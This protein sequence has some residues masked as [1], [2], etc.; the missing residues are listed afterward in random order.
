MRSSAARILDTGTG[1]AEERFEELKAEL[2]RLVSNDPRLMICPADPLRDGSEF[3]GGVVIRPRE[4]TLDRYVEMRVAPCVAE[5]F[6]QPER[7][8]TRRVL[9]L[10]EGYCVDTCE[11]GSAQE[12]GRV[13]VGTL[14]THLEWLEHAVDPQ[15]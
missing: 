6:L 3:N 2:E 1:S 11:T 10:E 7:S 12:L 15:A 13:L 5:V 8:A 14:E 9:A 4:P